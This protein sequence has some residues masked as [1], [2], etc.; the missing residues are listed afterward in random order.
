M[1]RLEGGEGSE[2]VC[3][4]SERKTDRHR[5]GGAKKSACHTLTGTTVPMPRGPVPI[6][7]ASIGSPS[8][9]APVEGSAMV[10]SSQ[11]WGRRP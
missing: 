8:P 6:S 1:I 7:I 9:L 4:E 2:K 11:V 3:E 5:G 10:G